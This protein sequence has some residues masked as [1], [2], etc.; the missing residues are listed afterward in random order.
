MFQ[1]CK[2]QKLQIG[3]QIKKD[4]KTQFHLLEEVYQD[5]ELII[6]MTKVMDTI[7][8]QQIE[9]QAWQKLEIIHL[10]LSPA[11]KL[12]LQVQEVTNYQVILDI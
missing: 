7:Y 6:H 4:L 9:I 8:C 3:L 2:I 10:V 11:I 5:Q 1:R 12:S